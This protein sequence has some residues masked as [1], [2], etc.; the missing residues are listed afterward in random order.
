[1]NEVL[2]VSNVLLWLL[3]LA[4]GVM[5]MALAR[6]V[7]L[8]HE[9]SAPL[10]AVIADKGPDIGDD[11]PE[12]ELTDLRGRPVKIGGVRSDGRDLLLVFL[13]PN[14][15]MCNKLLPTVLSMARSEHLDVVIVS[16]GPREDHERFL[17]KHPIGNLPYVNSA[18]VGIRF[19]IGRVPYAVL[20][21]PAGKIRAKGLVNTREH[22]ESLVEAKS[23]DVPSIQQYLNTHSRSDHDGSVHRVPGVSAGHDGH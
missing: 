18:D 20:L 11:A 17:S 14:C 22:L 16:D 21:D 5:L 4:M 15:P 7:G 23:M 3:L 1:M 6:Q 9:R 12:F 8:L 13:G 19:Q 10:G 2:I